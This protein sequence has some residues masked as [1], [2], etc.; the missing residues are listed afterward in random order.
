MVKVKKVI[1][2]ALEV[3]CYIV[4]DDESLKAALIDPGESGSKV[5][6]E[7]KK[8]RLEP[9]ILINTHGHFD[10]IYSDD[11][12]R[13]EFKIPLAVFKDEVEMLADPYKNAS[14]PHTDFALSVKNPKILFE[15]NQE[16]K[17]SFTAFKVIHTPGHSEGG[18][19]LLFNNFLITGDTLFAGNI[20]R[21][22]L[23]GG[24]IEKM[25][26]SLAKIKKLR[27]DIT[28]YPGHSSQTTLANEFCHNPYL[29]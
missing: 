2:G 5:I 18:I 15:D 11:Q 14:K 8:E 7:I 6:A 22:D 27:P 9:E 21:T 26:Q 3:N 24:N 16:F 4:Y 10:H 23:P 28:V 29:K 12:I 1:S 25:R 20:G 19:C 13:K 17:L